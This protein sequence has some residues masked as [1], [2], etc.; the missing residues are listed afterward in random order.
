MQ[1][2]PDNYGRF[3]SPAKSHSLTHTHTRSLAR[4]LHPPPT[5]SL[6]SLTHSRTH[7][8]NYSLTPSLTTSPPRPLTCLL[9]P[10]LTHGTMARRARCVWSCATRTRSGNRR[11]QAQ[12]KNTKWSSSSTRSSISTDVSFSPNA[13][14]RNAGDQRSA[15]QRGHST[16]AQHMHI[17]RAQHTDTA[18]GTARRHTHRNHQPDETV[19]QRRERVVAR[20]GVHPGGLVPAQAKHEGE[21]GARGVKGWI[22]KGRATTVRMGA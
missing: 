5:P 2:S 20:R 15:L 12:A 19:D 14:L 1:A 18:P 4:S 3:L 21:R 8:F 11:N 16:R 6:A 9:T 22:A 7:S 17:T 10:S 13:A